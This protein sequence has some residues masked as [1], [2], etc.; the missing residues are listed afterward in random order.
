M[1][2]KNSLLISA[3]FLLVSCETLT[4]GK[5]LFTSENV[6]D[7]SVVETSNKGLNSI[8]EKSSG[9]LNQTLELADKYIQSTKGQTQYREF[10]D[11]TINMGESEKTDYFQSLLPEQRTQILD[12]INNS[13]LMNN[14]N[15]S[16][17][18][19]KKA[20]ALKD[21]I[22][23]GFKENA[24]AMINPFGEGNAISKIT[25]QINYSLN[26]LKFLKDQGEIAGIIQ[27]LD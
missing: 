10:V 19:L 21:E 16:S 26:R 18:L 7:T 13:S 15:V 8:S 12:T 1:K 4:Q 6:P 22:Q 14:L 27:S 9:L 11:K 25:S 20:I 23:V 17:D 3:L 2:I 24:L 5:S